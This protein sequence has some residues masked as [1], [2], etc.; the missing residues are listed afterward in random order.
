MTAVGQGAIEGAVLTKT[1]TG[2]KVSKCI[3]TTPSTIALFSYS[4]TFIQSLSIKWKAFYFLLLI[5]KNELESPYLLIGKF[6][7]FTFSVATFLH[8]FIPSVGFIFPIYFVSSFSSSLFSEVFVIL[9]SS[10]LPCI[11][12]FYSIFVIR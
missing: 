2:F 8:N 4:F 1:M 9:H 5:L 3:I 11:C 7:P 6:S 12:N 10:F